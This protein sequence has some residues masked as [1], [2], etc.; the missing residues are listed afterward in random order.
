MASDEPAVR[1]LFVC[2][3]NTCRSPLAAAAL[4]GELGSDAARV[5]VLSAGTSAWEGQPASEGTR[6]V[7]ARAGMDLGSHRARRATT[8]LVRAA[9]L[10]FVMEPLH[11]VALEALGAPRERVHVLS[12][13]PEPGDP[14]LPVSDPFGGSREAYEECLQRI[15]QHVR[16]ITPAVR[17]ALRAR[18]AS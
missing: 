6:D 12:E 2:T 18:N 3:G 4:V 13:W 10:V 16:R 14:G 5:E 9:D 15:Q 11:R 7:A 17:E 8:P 1:V